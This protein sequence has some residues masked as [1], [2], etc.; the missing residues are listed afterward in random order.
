M[1]YV[2]TYDD[3]TSIKKIRFQN[4]ISLDLF[5][6]VQDLLYA[7]RQVDNN[8][9]EAGGMLIGRVLPYFLAGSIEKYLRNWNHHMGILAHGIRIHRVCQLHHQLISVTG[10]NASNKTVILPAHWYSSLPV[11]NLIEFG[12]SIQTW[13]TL[14]RGIYH[15]RVEKHSAENTR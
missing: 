9:P 14:S 11:Q 6:D 15:E 2:V 7:Y 1:I 10:R 12:F 5:P 4:G 3:R 13:A 8:T